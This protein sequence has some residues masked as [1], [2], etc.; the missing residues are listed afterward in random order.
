[1]HDPKVHR[2]YRYVCRFD[3]LWQDFERSMAYVDRRY[4]LDMAMPFLPSLK[5]REPDDLTGAETFLAGDWGASFAEELVGR[6][7]KRFCQWI[8]SIKIPDVYDQYKVDIDSDA[9]FLTFNYTD[10]L[11]TKYG[12]DPS[13]IK[14]IHGQRMSGSKSLVVGHGEDENAIFDKWFRRAVRKRKIVKKGK[15]IWIPS[16]YKKFYVEP[17]CYIPEYQHVAERIEVYY[18]EAKKPV[19]KI[20]KSEHDYFADLH[21]V[22]QIV[23]MGFSFSK[24][25]MPYLQTIKSV[26]D[27][28]N[29]IIWRV[30]YY[31]D[32]DMQRASDA[33][34]GIGVEAN[35][36][37]F[38]KISDLQLNSNNQ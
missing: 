5:G 4:F 24:V 12:I 14:H 1:M 30:S 37:R 22:K 28:P 8:S 7:K 36:I 13:N 16:V 15:E 6:L 27:S 34:L 20:I 26:N 29:G 38:F 17:Y 21:D 35:I 23:V 31:S 10:C 25:D 2:I 11:E 19:A 18:E 33:L 3:K 32:D 9:R